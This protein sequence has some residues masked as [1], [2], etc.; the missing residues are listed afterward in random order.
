MWPRVDRHDMRSK[1]QLHCTSHQYFNADEPCYLLTAR[2]RFS[3][4]SQ[5]THKRLIDPRD[6]NDLIGQ[7]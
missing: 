4:H 6:G 1:V 7:K 2:L 3:Y 5:V